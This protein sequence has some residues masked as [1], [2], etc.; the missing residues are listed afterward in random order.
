MM[1]S[2]VV[3]ILGIIYYYLQNNYQGPA[4]DVSNEPRRVTDNVIPS[5]PNPAPAANPD[6]GTGTLAV[7]PPSRWPRSR[8]SLRR[9][10]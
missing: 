7:K 8:P 6:G 2:F 10:K 5:T 9:L 3:L 4:S 1:I